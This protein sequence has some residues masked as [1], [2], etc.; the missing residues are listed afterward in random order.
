M[1][2]FLVALILFRSHV[3][4]H[5]TATCY[6]LFFFLFI[7]QMSRRWWCC[8]L[9]N[10]QYSVYALTVPLMWVFT[11]FIPFILGLTVWSGLSFLSQNK[12][13]WREIMS[14][15]RKKKNTVLN[16]R[17][18]IN[19][20]CVFYVFGSMG[21]RFKGLAAGHDC[22]KSHMSLALTVSL[23]LVV[24]GSLFIGNVK[25]QAVVTA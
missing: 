18:I 12:D 14:L 6:F 5:K 13:D 25:I 19:A 16:R 20:G 15:K 9:L 23:T 21:G 3:S 22:T 17:K 24:S 4:S 1:F 2:F 11:G 10:Q 7:A 8:N